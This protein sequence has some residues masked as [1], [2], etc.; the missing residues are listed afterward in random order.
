MS[1]M[2]HAYFAAQSG[3][4][5]MVLQ[6][7]ERAASRETPPETNKGAEQH[8]SRIVQAQTRKKWSRPLSQGKHGVSIRR[9]AH[10]PQTPVPCSRSG[11]I[12]PENPTVISSPYRHARPDP[13]LAVALLFSRERWLATSAQSLADEVWNLRARVDSATVVEGV[14]ADCHWRARLATTLEPTRSTQL[15]CPLLLLCIL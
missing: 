4:L 9:P 11:F 3:A 7:T 13:G 10:S 8:C 14:A 6:A 12:G 2:R 1:G 15:A 5:R